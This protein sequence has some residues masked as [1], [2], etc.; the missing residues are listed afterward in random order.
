MK[1]IAVGRS[2]LIS[3]RLA[4]GCWR[5]A[6]SKDTTTV[7]PEKEAA[8]RAA[9]LAAYEAGYTLFD[10][11]DIYADGAA[12]R[13]FGQALREVPEMR[14]RIV[15]CTKGGIRLAGVP[16]A[17]A[18]FRYD[19]SEAYLVSACEESLQRLGIETIDL[20]LLH[21]PDYLGDPTEVASAFSRL[22][23][24]GKVREFGV[25]NFRPSQLSLLQKACPMPLV[26]HQVE[27]SLGHLEPFNDGTLDQCLAEQI[28]PQ[29]WS[30]LGGGRLVNGFVDMQDPHHARKQKL[31]DTLGVLAREHGTTRTVLALAWL[32]KH[33]ARIMPVVGSINPERIQESTRADEL[34]LTREEWYR[35]YE[36]AAG[37]R[38]P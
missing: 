38:L 20:Y 29:A 24:T 4:Y 21:R 30:P 37:Q 6:G 22:K 3:T 13:I 12:E 31:H 7:T 14:D 9:V 26:A 10:L 25:S 34:E 33:P 35:L 19:F 15:I 18:P 8:G 23:Q 36:A 32:L 27:I 1:T 5:L 2:E 28:T 11:A 17:G 16:D